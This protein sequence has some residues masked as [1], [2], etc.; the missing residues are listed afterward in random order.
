MALGGMDWPAMTERTSPLGRDVEHA[1]G[2]PK[3][4]AAQRKGVL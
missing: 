3:V 2:L 4:A 1:G